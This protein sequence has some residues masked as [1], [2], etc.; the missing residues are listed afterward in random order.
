MTSTV[1]VAGLTEQD[2]EIINKLILHLKKVR[3]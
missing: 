3:N 2:I 1:S